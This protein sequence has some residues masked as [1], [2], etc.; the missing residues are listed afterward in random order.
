M[1]IYSHVLGDD[2]KE[3]VEQIESVLLRTNGA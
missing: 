1:E 3:A 2:H